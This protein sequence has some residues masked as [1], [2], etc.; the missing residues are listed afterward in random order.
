MNT[1]FYLLSGI[2]TNR[3]NQEN[4]PVQANKT[5]PSLSTTSRA[6]AS[7]GVLLRRPFRQVHPHNLLS[8]RSPEAHFVTAKAAATAALMD[9]TASERSNLEADTVHMRAASEEFERP[10][11]EEELTVI[12]Y[13]NVN[14][15]PEKR[16][17]SQMICVESNN[18]KSNASYKA[19][20]NT[21]EHGS[22][23]NSPASSDEEVKDVLF[24]SKP[25]NFSSSPPRGVQRLRRTISPRKFLANV[26]ATYTQSCWKSPRKRQRQASIGDLEATVMQ[27]PCLDLEK[28]QVHTISPLFGVVSL[29]SIYLYLYPKYFGMYDKISND[30]ISTTAYTLTK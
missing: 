17:W 7:P 3:G 22:S 10:S 28:M 14:Q 13:I 19:T 8:E 2:E 18:G 9:C 23:A 27:R 6:S 4:K 25:S 21:A 26:S 5:T 12:N 20:T 1:P 24:H 16:K 30:G 11:S 29:G 15:S